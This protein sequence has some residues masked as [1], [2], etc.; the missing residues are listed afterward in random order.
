[1]PPQRPRRY[2]GGSPPVALVPWPLQDNVSL[3]GCCARANRPNIA[4]PHLHCPHYY[5]SIARLLRN[6]RLLP[7]PSIVRHARYNI[8]HDNIV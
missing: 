5:N 6:K 3:Q 2:L 7:E 1:M 4:P 8:G